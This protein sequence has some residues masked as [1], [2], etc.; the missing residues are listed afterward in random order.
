MNGLSER[1]RIGTR[2]SKLARLQT[3]FVL[4]RLS[5]LVPEL[6]FETIAI[7][8]PGDR[9]QQLD[10][11]DSPP[12]FFTR[13]LDDQLLDGRIDGAVHSAKDLPDMPRTGIDFFWLPWREDS[14]DA[15][16]CRKGERVGD[17]PPDL[18][19]GVSS[20]RRV[21][22]CRRR[23]PRAT[24]Q[25][26]RGDIPRRLSQLDAG[27]YDL[28][29]IAGAALNRLG[30]ADRV[31]EWISADELQ[32]PEGQG[33]LALTYRSD[34]G[35][36]RAL[37]NLFVKAVTF[38]AAG[39][40]S[41]G[42]CTLET[43]RALEQADVCLYDALIGRDLLDHI[44][45]T[46]RLIDVGKRCGEQTLPQGTIND[47]LVQHVCHG[48][49]VVRLKGG[50]PGIFGRLAEETEA[51]DARQLP[52]RVLPGVSSLTA[53]TTPTGLLLTRRGASRGFTVM[54]P[55]REG[56]EIGSINATERAALTTVFFMSVQAA[57]EVARQLMTEDGLPPHTPAAVVFDAGSDQTEIVR[58]VL[59]DIASRVQAAANDAPG[60]LV[61]GQAAAHRFDRWGALAGQRV[62]ITASEAL[63]DRASARVIDFGGEPVRRPLIRLTV[64]DEALITLR[65]IDRYDWVILTSPSAVR[66][67][68]ELMIR[69]GID[70]RRI[71]KLAA[72]GSGT[73]RELR[74]L[75]LV[76][77]LEPTADFGAAGL[78]AAAQTAILP[79]ARVLRLGSAMADSSLSVSLRAA[80][81]Q[82]EDCL[83]YRNEP[84]GY[85]RM[86]AFDLAFFASASAVTAFDRLWGAKALAG[87]TVAAIG[88]PTAAALH[89]L[90]VDAIVTGAEATVDGVLEAL[91]LR[92]VRDHYFV[93]SS[94]SERGPG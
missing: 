22:Y 24:M 57:G 91:A 23:F 66:C 6:T 15:L 86:P 68:V 17:L 21:D 67:F 62:L 73:A 85:E 74:R 55:R 13:D 46:V 37:R 49:R 70:L 40:G 52:Y 53:A 7:S 50:D 54:T 2:E 29:L 20:T 59:A 14:R 32:A 27:D 65:T 88:R 10:L 93:P 69:G 11:R 63:Q 84:I 79:G 38:A 35:R 42:T 8:S 48:L 82:V 78:F 81:V 72:C 26:I 76:P 44:P 19:I 64:N 4:E 51:L 33:V 36:F 89:D 28:L 9:D 77:D 56:G 45:A 1:L 39:V 34:D 71:P 31:A 12:D 3:Q 61:V 58:G 94:P 60:L 92:V 16:V 5:G 83:L 47:L 30:L 18:R 87:K 41:A 25:P 43:L 75:G 80:G 90:G